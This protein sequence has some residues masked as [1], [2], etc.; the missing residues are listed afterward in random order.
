MLCRRDGWLIIQFSRRREN[1]PWST[2]AM[3]LNS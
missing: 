2:P 3:I 1:L